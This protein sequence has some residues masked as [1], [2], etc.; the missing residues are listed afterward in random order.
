MFSV[1]QLWILILLFPAIYLVSQAQVKHLPLDGLC[2]NWDFYVSCRTTRGPA[3]G[4]NDFKVATEMLQRMSTLDEV[5]T[6]S[7]NSENAE[8]ADSI[9]QCCYVRASSFWRNLWNTLLL[10]N[11]EN[12]DLFVKSVLL[13]F[14]ILTLWSCLSLFARRCLRLWVRDKIC[15]I[16]IDSG[17]FTRDDSSQVDYI[18]LTDNDISDKRLLEQIV[19]WSSLL[20][21]FRILYSEKVP[22]HGVLIRWTLDCQNHLTQSN[23]RNLSCPPKSNFLTTNWIVPL[24]QRKESSV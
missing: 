20:E 11:L 8:A 4:S 14:D 7:Q 24:C 15:S 23:R 6:V 18:S 2:K 16:L 1:T 5:T 22:L 17:H 12:D 19:Y 3:S 10:T 9:L 13:L 21:P